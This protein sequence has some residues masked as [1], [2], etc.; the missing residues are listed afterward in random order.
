MRSEIEYS[1]SHEV[2]NGLSM[3]IFKSKKNRK[4]AKYMRRTLKSKETYLQK[5]KVNYPFVECLAR[6]I[7]C[8][9]EI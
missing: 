2:G 6:K 4:F 1:K 9:R 5:T 8:C 7:E 3:K